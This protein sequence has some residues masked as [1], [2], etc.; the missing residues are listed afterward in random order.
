[1]TNMAM[2]VTASSRHEGGVHTLFGDGAIHFISES[3]DLNVWRAMGTRRG[4]EAVT[5][6]F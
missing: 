4:R 6:P 5:M 3:V 2:Q 1:M